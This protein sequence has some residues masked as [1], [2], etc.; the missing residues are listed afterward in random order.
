LFEVRRLLLITAGWLSLAAGLLGI[1]LPLLPTTPFLL[2][3]AFCFS[4][5]S[6]RLHAW[7]VGHSWFGP[8]IRHWQETRSVT[9]TAKMLAISLIGSSFTLTLLL[10]PVPPPVQFGVVLLAMVLL[11]VLVRLPQWAWNTHST[12]PLAVFERKAT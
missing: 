7:L 10:V 11:L 9:F 6:D 5:G 3:S 2:L 4:R 12:E 8:P 1:V